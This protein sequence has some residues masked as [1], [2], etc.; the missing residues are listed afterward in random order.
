MKSKLFRKYLDGDLECIDPISA[1]ADISD[2][3]D[4][5]AYW[6]DQCGSDLVRTILRPNG[7]P[8]A[9]VNANPVANGVLELYSF[10]DKSVEGC[11][12]HYVRAM[13]ALIDDAFVRLPETH[14][15]QLLI[16]ADQKWSSRW[17]SALHFDFEGR[18]RKYAGGKDHILYARLRA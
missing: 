16:R 8:L 6:I 17:A 4:T 10:V 13:R 1:L 12:L 11:A 18:L 5:A 7:L 14:R 3:R 15:L 9:V 2:A